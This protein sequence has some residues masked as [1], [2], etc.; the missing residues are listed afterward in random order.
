MI[1]SSALA[2]PFRRL[3][4]LGTS[5]GALALALGGRHVVLLRPFDLSASRP[6]VVRGPSHCLHMQFHLEGKTYIELQSLQ[7]GAAEAEERLLVQRLS[8][9]TCI[10]S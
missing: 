3:F 1:G 7:L 2:V 5:I 10:G 4:R 6:G 8:E 9:P